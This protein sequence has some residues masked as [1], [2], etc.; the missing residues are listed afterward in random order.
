[1]NSRITKLGIRKGGGCE[2]MFKCRRKRERG[3]ELAID[4][5]LN[6][7]CI[8]IKKGWCKITK[9]PE[10]VCSFRWP[11]DNIC[12]PYGGD[13]EIGWRRFMQD[14]A[15]P[16]FKSGEKFRL[17]TLKKW[18]NDLA[19]LEFAFSGTFKQMKISLCQPHADSLYHKWLKGED[20]A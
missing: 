1:M 7:N 9:M 13:A 3:V 16:L 15:T 2:K 20:Q 12:V 6:N 18:A 8:D 17:S 14:L 10:K 11:I 19:A 5:L 4:W